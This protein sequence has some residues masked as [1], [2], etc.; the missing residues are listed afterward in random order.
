MKKILTLITAAVLVL[1]L[2]TACGAKSADLSAVTDSVNSA[3]GL[4]DM[5][6]IEDT[7]SL[8]R[9]YQIAPEDVKQFSAE[10][11]SSAKDYNEIVIVEAADSTAAE[12][13]KAQLDERL[14]SQ[15]SNAKSYDA[16]QVS[17]IEACEVKTSGNF[18]YLVIGAD[19]D[20]IA[21]DI[22][23]ALK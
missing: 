10:L 4:S 8:N 5:K 13:V 15:L 23:A 7:D 14:R 9:Y 20:A 19:H 17:M 6:V 3:Y 12:N 21:A 18:V 22:E 11:S 2:C 16:E 1:I